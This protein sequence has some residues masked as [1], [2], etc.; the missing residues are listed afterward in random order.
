MYLEHTLASCQQVYFSDQIGHA[1]N[2][3]AQQEPTKLFT[4]AATELAR[5]AVARADGNRTNA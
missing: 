2:V 5:S 1:G 4:W 3:R